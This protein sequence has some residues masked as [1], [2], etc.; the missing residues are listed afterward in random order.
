VKPISA[1]IESGI[2]PVITAGRI[3]LSLMS[4]EVLGVGILGD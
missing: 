4:W 2:T 1:A 3:A